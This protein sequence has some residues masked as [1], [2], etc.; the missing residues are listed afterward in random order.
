MWMLPVL[1]ATATIMPG[2]RFGQRCADRLVNFIGDALKKQRRIA[3]D[4]ATHDYHFSSLILGIV[5][6]APFRMRTAS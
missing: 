1:V 5:Q 2:Q 6:S 3:R 4:A